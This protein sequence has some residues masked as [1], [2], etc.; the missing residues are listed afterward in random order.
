MFHRNICIDLQVHMELQPRRHQDLHSRGNL[1]P[2]KSAFS[3]SSRKELDC[4]ET[5]RS[6]S[7]ICVTNLH[8][9]C[10]SVSQLMFRAVTV[11]GI[12]P[13]DGGWETPPRS[14]LPTRACA[15]SH[16]HISLSPY[17]QTRSTKYKANRFVIFSIPTE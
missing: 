7:C 17:S 9:C 6:L 15:S 11:H 1:T 10:R 3:A 13:T 12:R 4:R 14:C 5:E 8:C 16:R 2:H